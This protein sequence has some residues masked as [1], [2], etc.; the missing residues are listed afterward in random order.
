MCQA[1]VSSISKE[2]A[3]SALPQDTTIT[4]IGC[5]YPDL[6]PNYIQATKCAY[7]IYTDPTGQIYNAL[8]M[9]S[10][11]DLGPR[12]PDYNKQGVFVTSVK[13]ALQ[14]FAWKGGRQVNR[15]GS[16]TQ[17]GGEFLFQRIKNQDLGMED[18]SV[19]YCH[20]MRNTRDHMETDQMRR[21]LCDGET[22]DAS[23]RVTG[24]VD[25]RIKDFACANG[26]CDPVKGISDRK[27]RSD[28][29]LGGL[30]KSTSNKATR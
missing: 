18:W 19:G 6:I 21:L 1:Y 24:N 23:S 3:P 20:R 10:T 22:G 7:P 5:G 29:L 4:I 14:V 16:W 15:G 27:K 13:S 26:E 9:T 17:V 12:A 30:R 11:L 28:S 2:L 8:H 25:I